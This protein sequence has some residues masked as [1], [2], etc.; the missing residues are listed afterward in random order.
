MLHCWDTEHFICFVN[1]LTVFVFINKFPYYCCKTDNLDQEICLIAENQRKY[2]L[3][4]FSLPI[5]IG[6]FCLHQT[7]FK[8]KGITI[9][10]KLVNSFFEYPSTRT[11]HIDIYLCTLY[12]NL[13][14]SFKVISGQVEIFCQIQACF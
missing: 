11:Q 7:T 14:H 5:W 13:L 4:H 12:C 3:W 8:R 1:N 6:S 10:Q 2:N 9:F